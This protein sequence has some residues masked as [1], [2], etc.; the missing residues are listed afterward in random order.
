[1]KLLV[2]MPFFAVLMEGMMYGDD[3][4][5]FFQRQGCCDAWKHKNPDASLRLSVLA[6]LVVFQKCRYC[7][8]RDTWCYKYRIPQEPMMGQMFKHLS[9]VIIRTRFR[10]PVR[11]L[12]DC[13]CLSSTT[14]TMTFEEVGYSIFR[15]NVQEGLGRTI[16]QKSN[17]LLLHFTS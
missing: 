2:S 4:G 14:L 8:Y 15:E 9:H 10:L 11:I 17:N 12:C 3:C 5:T 6:W 16:K 1:M 13:C 7:H